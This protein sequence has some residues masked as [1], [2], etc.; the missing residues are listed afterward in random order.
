MTREQEL[1]EDLQERNQALALANVEIGALN[2][3]VERLQ[4]LLK[5]IED[6]ALC[7]DELDGLDDIIAI[8]RE[9][10]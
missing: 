10:K 9:A 5:R 2:A 3:E 1:R 4:A 8:A 6:K 7:D